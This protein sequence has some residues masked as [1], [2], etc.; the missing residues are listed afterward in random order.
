M[1]SDV[2]T[3]VE[4]VRW[5]DQYHAVVVNGFEEAAM[6]LRDGVGWSS[7]PD[8]VLGASSGS[9]SEGVPPA[10][11]RAIVLMDAPDHTRMRSLLSPAFSPRVIE[12]LRPRVIAIVNTV[13]DGLED[14]DEA[15]I[16]AD[17]GR[18]VPPAI[19]AELLDVGVE[20]AQL[21]LEQAPQLVRWMEFNPTPEDFKATVEAA[22]ALRQFL[23]PIMEKRKREPG[24][25]FISALVAVKDGLSIDEILTTCYVVLSAGGEAVGRLISLATLAI[26]RDPAQI[27][28]LLADPGRAVEE[29]LRMEGTSRRLIRI[30]LTDQDLGGH[31]ITK[32]QLVFINVL[33]VNRDPRRAPDAHQLDLSRE[34]LGHLTFGIGPH[35][36]LGAALAR[37]QAT[38]TLVRLFTR[39]PGLTLTSR[40]PIWSSSTTFR[41]LTELPVRLRG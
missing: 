7:N 35:F 25:D 28:H 30:A 15:D 23:T 6:V 10:L 1:R 16:V 14:E 40:E 13:L 39:F 24:D 2:R 31:R 21:L 26:L 32:G 20:G 8:S 18:V 41:G 4:P 12:R 22:A 29:L 11:L 9:E 37:L 17:V 3:P 36:C 19:I 38:E 34:P 5:D 27:P 33:D